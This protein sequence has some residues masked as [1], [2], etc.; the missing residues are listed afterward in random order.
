MHDTS[1]MLSWVQDYNIAGFGTVPS[2]YV[3]DIHRA[4]PIVKNW[5]FIKADILLDTGVY[6]NYTQFD[7]IMPAWAFVIDVD[8]RHFGINNDDW[9]RLKADY[10]LQPILDETFIVK[11]KSGGYHIYLRKPENVSIRKSLLGYS[12]IE[13]LP[14]KVTGASSSGKRADGSAFQY[15]PVSGEITRIVEAPVSLI[16]AITRKPATLESNSDT[17]LNNPT[18]ILEFRRFLK[19]ASPAI[20]GQNGDRHTFMIAARGKEYNLSIEETY[21]Q[22]RQHFN[23]RCDPPWELDALRQK[24]ENAYQYTYDNQNTK[25]ITSL[26]DVVA[27][28]EPQT[29]TPQEPKDPM[30]N[31]SSPAAPGAKKALK[32]LKDH[33][34]YVCAVDYMG[35]DETKPVKATFRS[36]ITYF[37]AVPN[38]RNLFIRNEFS[39]EIELSFNVPWMKLRSTKEPVLREEDI[40][41]MEMY[42]ASKFN[43]AFD[44]KTILRAVTFLA[45]CRAY[46]PV[47]N[48][49][50]GLAW[51][52][53]NRLDDVFVRLMHAQDSEYTRAVTRKTFVGAVA[54]VFEP[55]CQWDY[56]LILEGAEGLRKSSFIRVMAGQWGAEFNVDPK[57][58][59]TVE[60]MRGAWLV[61]IAEMVAARSTESR[62]L[63]AFLTR[64]IDRMR[65]PYAKS[66]E[67]FRRQGIFIGTSNP[68]QVG[69]LDP[70]SENRRYWIVEVFKRLDED[71]LKAER[72]Q[73][74][75]EAYHFYRKG[76]KLY[77]DEDLELTARKIAKHRTPQDPWY[78]PIA[79]WADVHYKPNDRL[80]VQVILETLLGMPLSKAT[81]R[82]QIRI[83]AIL[84][85]IGFSKVEA[86][87][88]YKYFTR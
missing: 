42:F 56:T 3:D 51:D 2:R 40:L 60:M 67:D 64:R 12:G 58:K 81:R 87:S 78:E 54:R 5:Q 63:M 55:G 76:E 37:R 73:L 33:L 52:G 72:D 24:I 7:V 11:T 46:N 6:K 34:P 65:L 50:Y 28:P 9:T 13:F 68:D 57:H 85:T 23:P 35:N 88:G 20:E 15:T 70:N 41:H 49:I 59:D 80:T 26:F 14:L 43:I 62:A 8:P 1:T 84:I 18:D 69:Y 17:P 77:L 4:V 79:H 82:D 71:A 44:E 36:L 86:E 32:D 10:N 21:K 38:L 16:E 74:W 19:A 25:G 75:A 47:K 22:M 48:Y 53:K 39:G 61:E 45:N 31:F 30:A 66:S 27:T 29:P 83:E